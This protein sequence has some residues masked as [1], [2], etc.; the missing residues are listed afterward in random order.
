MSF[1]AISLIPAIF[2]AT[3]HEMNAYGIQDYSKQG[4]AT[5]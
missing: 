1:L 2:G 4:F 5:T 3:V